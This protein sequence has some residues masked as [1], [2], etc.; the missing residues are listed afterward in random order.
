MLLL[1]DMARTTGLGWD[2]IMSAELVK[3][4]KPAD[5]LYKLAI[6]CLGNG[7][8]QVLYVAAHKWDVQAGQ[9]AGLRAGYV[10]RWQFGKDG[11]PPEEPDPN[12]DVVGDDLGDLATKLGA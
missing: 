9:A 3:A 8:S 7:P 1:A 4:Y 5:A 12:F 2:C 11:D 10:L 6:D